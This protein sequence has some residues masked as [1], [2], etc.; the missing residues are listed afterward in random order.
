MVGGDDNA[1]ASCDGRVESNAITWAVPGAA[2]DLYLIIAPTLGDASR[3]LL[4]LT[5]RPPVPP[6]WTMGYMQSRWGWVD[7]AYIDDALQQF[8]NRKL[9]VDAFI[10]D[11]EWYTTHPDYTVKPAGLPGFSDFD[12]NAKLFPDP[13][14]Q[15][16]Q[17]HDA[18][19]HFVGIRKPR[20]GN[21]ETLTM[22]RGKNWGFRPT[23]TRADESFD[24]RGL[25][26]A[27]PAVRAWYAKQIEPLLRAGIDGWWNDEGEF[28]YTN[29]LYW[30]MAEQT[31][32][33]AVRSDARL[34]TINRAFQP[35]L[36]RLGAAAWTGDVNASWHDFAR[37]P[38]DLLNWSVAGMPFNGCDIGGFG[39]ETTPELLV[40][41][42]E[43][44]TFFPI[45][46]A[47]SNLH[48]RPHFP[49]LFGNEAESAI[50][51]ALDLRY[52]LIPYFYSLAYRTHDTGEPMMR[53]LMMQYPNDPRVADLSSEWL[54]GRDLLVAPILS[55]VSHRRI[56]L[57]DDIWYDFQTSQRV[58]GGRDIDV[59]VPFDAVPLY[60]RSGTI[61][62][63]AP[64]IQHTRD[65]PGG[66]LDVQIYT[67]RDATFTLTEDD[68]STTAY[69]KGA[70]RR[71]TF[72]WSDAVQTLSWKRE[73][74]YDGNDCF[75]SMHITVH[76]GNST[77]TATRP[78]SP[79]V[80]DQSLSDS[81]GSVRANL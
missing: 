8:E 15:I 16:N 32:L 12:W 61:L 2:A 77:K 58:Q 27:A 30:N 25:W 40:R 74:T 22:I 34:W 41:W 6:R 29:Y 19:V 1:P 26:F 44:G 21:S 69:L 56:Y 51:K 31:A 3:G 33:D 11:F 70:L 13:A 68:G 59:D 57:P 79:I 65:L 18:G 64:L 9:P 4:S 66:P 52:R 63:F 48:A 37:T 17:L 20:L 5:G 81:S 45:M 67:G 50:R 76:N 10:F 55:P 71:T 75:R 47:H 49:W 53:P 7:R 38:T 54:I 14:V 28:T 46:R 42:M 24:A 78:T 43:A 73:G 60:V 62:T 39:G 80:H 23:G 36:S 35:G 72:I